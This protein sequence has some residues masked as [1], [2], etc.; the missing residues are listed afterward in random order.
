[1]DPAAR[2]RFDAALAATVAVDPY[3]HGSSPVS[4]ECDRRDATVEG[5]II[6][7]YVGGSVLT[8]TVVRVVSL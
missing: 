8:V 1:M 2:S 6:R 7:Y 4:D 5:V 3:G